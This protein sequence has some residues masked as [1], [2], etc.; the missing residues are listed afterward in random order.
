MTSG[1]YRLT[2]PSGNT[3]IGK[4]INI[5]VRWDQ[6]LDKMKKGKS[7]YLL[8]EEWNKY[9]TFSREILMQCHSDHIDIAEACY[10]S[11]LRPELNGTRPSDPLGHLSESEVAEI[12][13][14]LEMSTQDH[15]FTIKS[16]HSKMVDLEAENK[17]LKAKV[18]ELNRDRDE[19]ELEHDVSERIKKLKK[20]RDTIANEYE[21]L[22]E[23]AEC[24]D[25]ELKDIKARS[26]WQ[27]LFN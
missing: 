2:F 12:F 10:I 27:K 25:K 8:Q 16:F 18:E 7:A 23:E 17:Q 24:I 4:S 6:H 13:E 11:R 22:L 20:S 21:I 1:I 15:I 19:K 14:W 9:G 26:F 5:E 3:Y